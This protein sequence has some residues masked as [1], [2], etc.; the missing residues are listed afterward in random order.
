VAYLN[1]DQDAERQVIGAIILEP[2]YLGQVDLDPAD[3]YY[4][5][6]RRLFEIIL[7]LKQQGEDITQEAI[8]ERVESKEDEW[9]L[10]RAVSEALPLD[11]L[12]QATRVKELSRQRH[13]T[14]AMEKALRDFRKDNLTSTELA[15]RLRLALDSIT[16]P[17][18]TS[19]IISITNPRIVQTESP[20]YKLTVSSINGKNSAEIR[21]SSAELDKP[22]IFRRHIREKLR[23]NPLL[24][25]QYEEFIHKLVQQAEV[26]SEQ[27]DASSSET[28][29]YWIREWFSGANEAEDVED[30]TQGYIKRER[31]RWFSAERLLRFISE[32][33]KTKLNRSELWAVISDRGGK[34]SR[35]F[36][37][38]DKV[39]KLWGL[40]ESFFEQ[41]ALIEGDQLEL[42]KEDDDLRWLED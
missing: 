18:R 24:P 6:H 1:Y 28:V 37:L 20:V 7:S 29:C 27:E 12:A 33:G 36:R 39:V 17:S 25:K 2:S 31:A 8:R 41:E 40:D 16:L 9:A 22:A 4:S 15:D 30:L 11:C 21:L 5:D 13:L 14:N 34:K 35:N 26:E 23:I 19:R 32:H 10:I 3:F 42:Q 38:G